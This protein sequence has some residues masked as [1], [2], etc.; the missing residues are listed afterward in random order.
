[1][2]ITPPST[3][4]KRKTIKRESRIYVVRVDTCNGEE[5]THLVRAYHP[6]VALRF[7]ARDMIDVKV[8][9]Q[10]ELVALTSDGIGVEDACSMSAAIAT[11]DREAEIPAETSH[12]V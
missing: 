1:M 7:V 8:A 2:T 5:Q 12:A 3:T 11:D 4:I 10:D 6:G 9:S